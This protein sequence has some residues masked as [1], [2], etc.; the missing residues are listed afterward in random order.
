ML[1]YVITIAISV[2]FVPHY[3][4]I[5]WEPLRTNPWDIVVGIALTWILVGINIVGIQEAARLNI[6]LAVVDFATQLLLVAARRVPD[7]PP[8]DAARQRPL[9]HRADVERSSCSRSR[10][11]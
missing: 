6:A 10:S 9:G 7:L 11:G 8:P 5:F 3:L 2:I 4:A 1:N